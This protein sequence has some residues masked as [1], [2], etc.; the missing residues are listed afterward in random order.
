MASMRER[1][2]TALLE[3]WGDKSS[4]EYDSAHSLDQQAF[5]EKVKAFQTDVI[6]RTIEIAGRND[7]SIEEI[8][9][10]FDNT[11][12]NQRNPNSSRS[13]LVKSHA[14]LIRQNSNLRDIYLQE[15]NLD[16][17]E[18]WRFLLFRIAT[19]LGFAAIVLLTGFLAKTWG[20]PLPLLRMV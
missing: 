5:T 20:I 16:L 18:R 17:K 19:G 4:R 7:L 2:R 9:N 10:Q 11:R 15:S 12:G 8:A 14:I 3:Y 6:S 13:D 1:L